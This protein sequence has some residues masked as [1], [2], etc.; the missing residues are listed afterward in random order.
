MTEAD[1]RNAIRG[2]LEKHNK[3]VEQAIRRELADVTDLEDSDRLQFEVDPYG[4]G[5]HLVQTEEGVFDGDDLYESIP[6]T[7][8]KAADEADVDLYQLLLEELFPWLAT[9]W[10]V[11]GGPGRFSPAYAYF[12][13][14]LHQPRYHLERRRWCSVEEVWPPSG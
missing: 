12:H 6:E 7:I 13:G 8:R 2:V 11:V 5:I 9:R 1:F 10:Q 3:A 4:P 14:G